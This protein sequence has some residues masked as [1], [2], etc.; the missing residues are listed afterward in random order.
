MGPALEAAGYYGNIKLMI[1]DDQR[2]LAP[3]W[4][5]EVF[6]GNKE[7]GDLAK[8]VLHKFISTA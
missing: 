8:K 5:K 1:L 2:P 3:K 4:T 6:D 7:E